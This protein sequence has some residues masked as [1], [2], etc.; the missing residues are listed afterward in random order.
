MILHIHSF[1]NNSQHIPTVTRK[2][3]NHGIWNVFCKVTA[4][5]GLRVVSYLP[6]RSA[7]KTW[8][9]GV[10]TQSMRVL[11]TACT[12]LPT[13]LPKKL[14][15]QE[16]TGSQNPRSK[17]SKMPLRPLPKKGV[18]AIANS[19]TVAY[20]KHKEATIWTANSQWECRWNTRS[21]SGFWELEQICREVIVL[22]GSE[23]QRPW[24]YRARQ[25][26]FGQERMVLERLHLDVSS[27]V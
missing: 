19:A 3:L 12:S 6:G 13:F 26:C 14:D 4:M 7:L 23:R 16:S 15:G 5:Y 22:M 8:A 20:Q 2:F 18:N 9:S 17:G 11:A 21:R 10:S 27:V 24:I 25:R 1:H